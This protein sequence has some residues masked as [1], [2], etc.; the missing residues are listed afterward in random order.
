[1]SEMN[2]TE[3]EEAL[4]YTLLHST[5]DVDQQALAT[6]TFYRDKANHGW[7][8]A[9]AAIARIM[10]MK[11]VIEQVL[12][13]PETPDFWERELK[14]IVANTITEISKPNLN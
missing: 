10:A 11:E 8:V 7:Q 14:A 1:M 13:H 12:E 2:I 6:I 4:L 3:E 5:D 9:E